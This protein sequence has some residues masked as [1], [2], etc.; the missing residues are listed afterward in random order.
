MIAGDL[1]LDGEVTTEQEER[2]HWVSGW[3]SAD[4][5]GNETC[6]EGLKKKEGS[7]LV[8]PPGVSYISIRIYIQLVKSIWDVL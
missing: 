5:Q 1:R 8:I 2:E 6:C 4:K 7:T 3:V